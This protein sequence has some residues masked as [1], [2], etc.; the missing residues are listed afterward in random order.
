MGVGALLTCNITQVFENSNKKHLQFPI[1]QGIVI[2]RRTGV[3]GCK[4]RKT[5]GEES[6][7]FIGQDAG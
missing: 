6:P 4:C 3:R 1:I 2:I 5:A 7:G